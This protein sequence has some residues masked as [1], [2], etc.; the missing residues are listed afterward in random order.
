MSSKKST[1]SI[2]KAKRDRK[3]EQE[4]G[5]MTFFNQYAEL[6]DKRNKGDL[7][8]VWQVAQSLIVC[9]LP[10][11]EVADTHWERTARLGDGSKITVTF[12][13]A[14]RH[15]PLPYGQD[16]GPLFFMINRSIE[17]YQQIDRELPPDMDP[18]ERA[19]CLNQARFVEWERAAEYLTIM[20]KGKGGKDYKL[21]AE[22]LERIG[23]CNISVVRY[24]GSVKEKLLTPLIR[25]SRAP[26]W[27]MEKEEKDK[28]KESG[29]VVAIPTKSTGPLGFEF[30]EGFFRDFVANSVP[31]PLEVIRVLLR[32]PKHL[33]LFAFL[34]WRGF[35]AESSSY[36][37]I[38][39]LQQ[40]I[41]STDQNISRLA[42][43]IEKII[44]LSKDLG[45]KELNAEITY[46]KA[47][48]R[49]LKIGKPKNNVHFLPS[50]S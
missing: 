36:I 13:A 27:A 11:D 40:Q 25:T 28:S 16:R 30:D 39:I 41:G 15:I 38:K 8:E 9:G 3:Q 21:L 18:R 35:A 14:E 20:E 4:R 26:R 48:R 5:Q 33:D 10:Y 29:K 12:S 37:P 47:G 1:V 2:E 45:W 49:C 19:E 32:R 24:V 6:H 7:T 43:D 22:R 17:R 23:N 50:G 42:K 46:D 34:C 31:V 44:K